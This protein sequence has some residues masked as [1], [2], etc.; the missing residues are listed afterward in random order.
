M[1]FNVFLFSHRCF[2]QLWF[3]WA[4]E[5]TIVSRDDVG[6]PSYW[7]ARVL[8]LGLYC[9]RR[10]QAMD[11]SNSNYSCNYI[12]PSKRF[13]ICRQLLR[14]FILSA[15][16]RRD[17]V[18]LRRFE[19]RLTTYKMLALN[20]TRPTFLWPIWLFLLADMAFSCGRCG[21]G[22]YGLWPIS[23]WPIWSVADMVQTRYRR[24]YEKIA[25][26]DQYLALSRKRYNIW[27]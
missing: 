22:R 16:A 14:S 9:R 2:L 23:L 4:V 10:T 20:S 5:L 15:Y 18:G 19:S 13:E 17:C 25:I 26:F 27:P 12:L 8:V 3:K 6:Q 11:S 7:A 21:R 1:F 24:G